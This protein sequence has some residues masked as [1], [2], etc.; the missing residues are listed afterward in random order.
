[1]RNLA[2]YVVCIDR[3]TGDKVSRAGPL[4]SQASVGNVNM[5]AGEWN[6]DFLD[7][8]E[9]F[10]YGRYKDQV[11]CTGGALTKLAEGEPWSDAAAGTRPQ[12]QVR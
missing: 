2:G 11:D 3:V 4:G 8:I 7:E 9:V 10:P 12:A 6:K 5:L 1:V